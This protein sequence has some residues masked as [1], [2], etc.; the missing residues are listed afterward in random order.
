MIK[1]RTWVCIFA[2]LA[3]LCAGVMLLQSR[4]QTGH[5]AQILQDG[6]LLYEIDLDRVDAPYEL[7]IEAENGGSNTVRVE[8]GRI[9]VADA[10]C[11]DR[12][13]VDFGYLSNGPAPIVCAPH[14]LMIRLTGESTVD[15]VAR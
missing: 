5:T 4:T 9:R 7:V 8:K 1:T 14:R 6:K 12:V 2:A 13:C 11:P 15:G 3:L 10:D